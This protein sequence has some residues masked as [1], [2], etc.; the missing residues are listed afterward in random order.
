MQKREAVVGS[1][2]SKFLLFLWLIIIWHL[3]MT[4]LPNFY[5]PKWWT[6]ED[7]PPPLFVPSSHGL[8]RAVPPLKHFASHGWCNF[9]NI[10]LLSAAEVWQSDP[11][12]QQ[13]ELEKF[14]EYLPSMEK[15]TSSLKKHLQRII[16]KLNTRHTFQYGETPKKP[17]NISW[18]SAKQHLN[19]LRRMRRLEWQRS[20]DQCN[21]GSQE[22]SK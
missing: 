13:Y 7:V 9:S 10:R 15:Q 6:C 5:S 4:H 16:S 17:G 14:K 22:K 21:Y 19:C 3:P 2:S 11:L 20:W 12:F 1:N 8:F 18:L